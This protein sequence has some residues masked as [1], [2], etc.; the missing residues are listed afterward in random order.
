MKSGA[1][2][3]V[4]DSDFNAFGFIPGETNAAYVLLTDTGGGSYLFPFDVTGQCDNAVEPLVIYVDLDFEIPEPS[5][6]G[7]GFAPSLDEWTVIYHPVNL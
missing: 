2:D 5:G 6:G 1:D 7:G 4:L 3:S